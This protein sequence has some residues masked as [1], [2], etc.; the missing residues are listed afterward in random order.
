MQA[1]FFSKAKKK[2]KE[3]EVREK[4]TEEVKIIYLKKNELFVEIGPL[5]VTENSCLMQYLTEGMHDRAKIT[6]PSSLVLIR[7]CYTPLS[8]TEQLA[9]AD[10]V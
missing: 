5:L 7:S 10:L 2:K 1:S 4:S 6:C 8:E 9:W 3:S